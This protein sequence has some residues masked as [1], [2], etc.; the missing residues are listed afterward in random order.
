MS[1]RSV[2]H[3]R[4]RNACRWRLQDD[5]TL[6]VTQS[7]SIISHS[8]HRSNTVRTY[9]HS[10]R[11]IRVWYHSW[12]TVCKTVRPMLSDRCLSCLS[13]T[14]VYCGQTL[15]RLKMKLGTQVGLG[16]CHIVL[17]GTYLPQKGH[18]PPN[19]WPMSV[20]AK[21]LDGWRCHLVRK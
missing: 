10:T 1:I 13:V 6:S 19:F 21:R 8:T 3:K 11:I 14:L 18:A 2:L 7:L 9:T 16:P 12:A 5:A 15:G 17:N 4:H 20:L